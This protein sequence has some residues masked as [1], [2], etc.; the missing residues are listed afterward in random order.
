MISVKDQ[1]KFLS[2]GTIAT[3]INEV[4]E[5]KGYVTYDETDAF[6]LKLYNE[7][8]ENDENWVQTFQRLKS[9]IQRD[10]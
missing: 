6:Q 4:Y 3:L 1:V 5:R 7:I 10:K 8:D 2:A 9:K